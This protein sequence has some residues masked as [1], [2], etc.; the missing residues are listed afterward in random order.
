MTATHPQTASGGAAERQQTK[1]ALRHR[2]AERGVDRTLWLLLPS[3]AFAGLLFVYPFIYGLQLSFSPEHGS[4]A[5]VNYER[6]F[7]DPYLRDTIWKTLGLGLPAAL[8]NVLASVP[9]AYLMRGQVRGK[10]ALTTILV[11]PIT[12]GTVLTAQGIIMYAGPTGWLNRI[13]MGMGVVDSPIKLVH[14]WIGV[15]LSLVITGFPFAFLLMLSYI[16][17]I[18]PSLEKAAATMGAGAVQRFRLI[19]MPLLAPGLAITF[20]LSFVL[21]FS[22]FPSANL[23]GDPSGSTRVLSIAAYQAAFQKFDYSMGSTI[24]M[25]MAVVMLIVIGLVM[26]WRNLLYRGSTGGKG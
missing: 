11:V 13:L 1:G 8:F 2:L 18:D 9:I 19:I 23:V 24:A 6:F 21:A 20:T 26:A 22:V 14:N 7:Q 10:R 25:I 3:V 15:F 4:G 5:F 16:S 12:L 17:G